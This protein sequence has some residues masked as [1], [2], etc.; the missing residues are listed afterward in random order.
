MSVPLNKQDYERFVKLAD[1]IMKH[2]EGELSIYVGTD[3][4]AS[5]Y[6]HIELKT[7]NLSTGVLNEIF[8][9]N[10]E[11]QPPVSESDQAQEQEAE[12]PEISEPEIPT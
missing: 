12:L 4:K 8:G 3:R 9:V 5:N 1:A 10:K 7:N 6:V 11:A 2:G